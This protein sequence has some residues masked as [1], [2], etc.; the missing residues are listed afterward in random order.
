MLR[1]PNE[2]LKF[3]VGNVSNVELRDPSI[4][5]TIPVGFPPYN[6]SINTG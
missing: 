2:N 4:L 3:S 6:I 1:G 5:K